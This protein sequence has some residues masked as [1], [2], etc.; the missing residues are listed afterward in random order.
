MAESM[1]ETAAAL[2][3]HT[4]IQVRMYDG[5]PPRRGRGSDLAKRILRLPEKQPAQIVT[6]ED[7]SIVSRESFDWTPSRARLV[8][9]RLAN[10]FRALG[11]WAT[12]T[13]LRM[14]RRT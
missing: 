8:G 5:N 1:G 12:L 7:G 9:E 11:R 14:T 4:A 3:V 6:V 13:Y 10:Y 2:E